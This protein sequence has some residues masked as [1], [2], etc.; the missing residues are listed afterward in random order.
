[1]K[2]FIILLASCIYLAASVYR[3]DDLGAKPDGTSDAAPAIYRAA[4][5]ATQTAAASAVIEFS[6]GVYYV[7]P[8]VTNQ[9][10]AL[11]F[12]GISN[13]TFRGKGTNTVILVGRP[14]YGAF[15]FSRCLN[16]AV[17]NIAID[18]AVVPFT[19]GTIDSVDM[20]AGWY[21]LAVDAGYPSPLEP[22]FADAKASWG[23]KAVPGV[24][25][26][27]IVHRPSAITLRGERMFRFAYKDGAT[28]KKA[29]L[30]AGDRFA[31]GFRW[32]VQSA[33]GAWDCTDVRVKNVAIYA[34]P[35]V[36]T[37]WANTSNVT[38]DGLTI[39]R[40]PGSDRL[41]S[42]CADGIH[43][44]GV[45]GTFI[46][47]NCRFEAMLDDAVN[48][49][50]RAALVWS[51]ISPTEFV[52]NNSGTFRCAAGDRIQLFDPLAGKIRTETRVA[53]IETISP[54][55]NRITVTSP[56]SGLTAGKTTRDADNVYNLD[57]SGGRV[58]IRSNYFGRHRGRS[59]LIKSD[60]LI[61]DNRFEN[62]DGLAIA[63]IKESE[64][65]E[66]PVPHDIAIERNTF[67]GVPRLGSYA[68][69]AIRAMVSAHG[70]MSSNRDIRNIVIRDNSFLEPR[71]GGIDLRNTAGAAIESNVF[72]TMLP[73]AHDFAL[74]SVNIM[75]SRNV[76]IDTLTVSDINSNAGSAV[77]IHQSADA[78]DEGVIIRNLTT[79]LPSGVKA[80]DDG[81]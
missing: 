37:T 5:S 17:E 27:L 56:I 51:N 59:I 72:R 73:G 8:P 53:A 77:R 78:G 71:V 11:D 19:Q 14:P 50:C 2:Y 66:G 60:A 58:I 61:H 54:F 47:E 49:H 52:I 75:Q 76:I 63:I 23:I 22:F 1:M 65:A 46:I 62:I 16:I 48:I 69:P 74:P 29:G 24:F 18:Y 68:Q 7:M 34:A 21:D 79:G 3:V 30:A 39:A 28:I 20:N 15:R 38:I 6:T 9:I 33:V 13:V 43:S 12:S 67:T 4:A 36:T 32:Y 44:F 81:R 25:Y 55:L 70:G 31:H 26:D 41:I 40:K 10:A 35:A 57:A 80:V 42:S 64:Y 45:R